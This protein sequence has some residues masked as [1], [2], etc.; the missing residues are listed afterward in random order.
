MGNKSW[1]RQ[2]S[3]TNRVEKYL[4]K[5]GTIS[6]TQAEA[7]GV[8]VPGHLATI[9]H[10]LRHKRLLNIVALDRRELQWNQNE[11]QAYRLLEDGKSK[12]SLVLQPIKNPTEEE[13]TA[14]IKSSKLKCVRKISDPSTGDLWYWP[15][16]QGT[17]AEG[18]DFLNIAYDKEPGTGEIVVLG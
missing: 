14:L 8:R 7:L 6:T 15:A 2:E 18:A 11:E 10:R 13:I 17:H 16:E 4:I 12:S 5:H 9:I 1:L 3:G